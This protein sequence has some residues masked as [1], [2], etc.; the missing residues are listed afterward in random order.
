MECISLGWNCDSA[1]FGVTSGARKKRENGYKTCPF[2]EMITNYDGL[3]N[4]INDDFEFLYDTKY[5]ELIKVPSDSKWLNTHGNGDIMIYNKKYN[6]LFNHESPHADLHI[7]Q[8]WKNGEYH[9]IM[10]DYAEFINRYKRRTEN[11]KEY[12]KSGKHIVFILT[13]PIVDGNISA[14]NNV[15]KNKYP[16]LSYRIINLDCDKSVVYDHLLLMNI[17]KENNEIKRLQIR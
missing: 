14:L 7:H 6:F 12:L 1:K 4:C 15:I 9:Y 8:N 3:V 2:D 17:D 10:N 5:L 13:R 16:S 11:F